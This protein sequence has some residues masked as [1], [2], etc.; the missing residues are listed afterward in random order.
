MVPNRIVCVFR[1]ERPKQ[2]P[3]NA[4]RRCFVAPL[5]IEGGVDHQPVV[6]VAGGAD[7]EDRLSMVACRYGVK[8]DLEPLNLD[9]FQGADLRKKTDAPPGFA[10]KGPVAPELGTREL[11]TGNP[12]LLKWL[13]AVLRDSDTD[14]ESILDRLENEAEKFRE[15]VL[16]EALLEPLRAPVLRTLALLAVRRLPVPVEAVRA[17]T[18]DPDLPGHP[19][20]PTNLGLAERIAAGEGDGGILCLAAGG[21]NAGRG[22]DRGGGDGSATGGGPGR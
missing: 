1:E 9:S 5:E 16:P 21:E 11:A 19:E 14:S 12:R 7:V 18:D 15:D 2:P 8:F 10:E 4:A 17:L 22:I 20:R 6:S 3:E 13:D